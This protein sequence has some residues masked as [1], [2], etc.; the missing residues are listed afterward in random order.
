MSP[1]YLPWFKVIVLP[2][3]QRHAG[4]FLFGFVLLFGLVESSQLLHFHL[5]LMTGML[6]SWV[7]LSLVTASWAVYTLKVIHFIHKE[8]QLRPNQFMLLYQLLTQSE[9]RKL[10]WKVVLVLLEPV[11]AYVVIL[12]AVGIYFEQYLAS[13]FAGSAV[14]LLMIATVEAVRH[15][16]NHPEQVTF[17]NR[18]F[19][20]LTPTFHR[21]LPLIFWTQ[22]WRHEPW[23]VILTKLFNL[24]AIYLV[25]SNMDDHADFRVGALTCLAV[26]VAHSSWIFEMRRFEEQQLV[27]LRNFPWSTWQRL[28]PIITLTCLMILPEALLWLR[29]LDDKI[30]IFQWLA[31]YGWTVAVMLF[32]HSLSF[33]RP[34]MES[35]LPATLGAF[36]VLFILVLFKAVPLLV[37][38]L[39]VWT[40]VLW[41]RR[42][43]QTDP[44]VMLGRS[45]R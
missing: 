25:S 42:Y 30:T 35:Y 37:V 3:Y 5:A 36:L 16:I 39:P 6:T 41:H 22:S 9:Q 2:F 21:P 20:L 17:G 13:L 23:G 12:M 43:Y 38:L 29:A 40:L 26:A 31:L 19:S 28:A 1:L 7:M 44:A 27:F 11:W 18:L 24:F 33:L 8:L 4:L 10:L 14:I 34:T 32:F 45:T 15:R